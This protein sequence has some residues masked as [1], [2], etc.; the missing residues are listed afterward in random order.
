M[1][2]LFV[3]LLGLLLLSSCGKDADTEVELEI[4]YSPV[5]EELSREH[6][7]QF[8][9]VL[10]ATQSNSSKG[11]FVDAFFK[12][13][14]RLYPNLKFRNYF[15]W[16]YGIKA[17][18]SDKKVKSILKK[19]CDAAL[20]RMM[21][22]MESNLPEAISYEGYER[23]SDSRIKL[24]LKTKLNQGELQKYFQ[25]SI[26]LSFHRTISFLFY[27]DLHKHMQQS[28]MPIADSSAVNEEGEELPSLIQ[29]ADESSR[30]ESIWSKLI[31][32][33]RVPYA[34]CETQYA[35][36]LLDSLHQFDLNEFNGKFRYFTKDE[37]IDGKNMTTIYMSP[38]KPNPEVALTG[39]HIADA[40]SGQDNSGAYAVY[41]QLNAKGTSMFTRLSTEE[42]GNPVLIVVNGEIIA[43]PVIN[44][45]IRGG[46]VQISGG[47][48][49]AAAEELAALLTRK[50]WSLPCEVLSVKKLK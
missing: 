6:S 31:F 36:E 4:D 7:M 14:K 28:L 19:R 29:L 45:P 18:M 43:A 44:G 3:F 5:F 50:N 8:K 27:D 49:G 24:F 22:G 47:F 46:N 1:K 38:A 16:K 41:I 15:Q 9:E 2:S 13:A 17:G 10:K 30:K 48:D 33:N 26:K 12:N 21:D 37:V 32:P 39:K 35:G 40:M 25:A 34:I 11:H 20:D 42:V 23:I